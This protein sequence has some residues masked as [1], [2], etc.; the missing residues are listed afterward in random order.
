[1]QIKRD[2]KKRT[3]NF[4]KKAIELVGKLPKNLANEILSFQFIKAAVSM[5][6]NYR[7]ADGAESARDFVHKIG[8]IIKEA[9]EAFYLLGLLQ[10]TNKSLNDLNDE[11]EWLINENGELIKIFSKISLNVKSKLK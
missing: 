6:A 9:K 10:F 2:L 4:A 7:E 1:M 5:G 8:V 3:F 11:F